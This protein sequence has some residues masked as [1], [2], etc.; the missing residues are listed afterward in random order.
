[1]SVCCGVRRRILLT[2][3]RSVVLSDKYAF[4]GQS[5]RTISVSALVGSSPMY[6][7]PKYAMGLKYPCVTPF[8]WMSSMAIFM[9]SSV[10]YGISR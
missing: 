2:W 8:F 10:V 3:A 1:M 9:K 7:S 5:A 4:H 6:P